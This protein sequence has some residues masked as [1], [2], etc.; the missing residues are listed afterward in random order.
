MGLHKTGRRK[1]KHSDNNDLIDCEW[2]QQT[3][4][5]LIKFDTSERIFAIEDRL[6]MGKSQLLKKLK[7]LCDEQRL[8]A[9]LISPEGL[10]SL[11]PHAF[12]SKIVNDLAP[13]P[14]LRER[15]FPR[16]DRLEAARTFGDVHSI[17]TS[18]TIRSEI[19]LEEANFEKARDVDI[20]GNQTKIGAVKHFHASSGTA[21][22][23]AEQESRAL[24]ESIKAF[25][26]DLTDLCNKHKTIFLIDAYEKFSEDSLFEDWLL[27]DFLE[28]LFL[29]QESRPDKL[30]LVIAGRKLPEF[31]DQGWI[32]Q[33]EHLVRI[34][35]QIGRWKREH[36]AE[37]MRRE[38]LE[39]NDR[40]LDMFLS[41]VET[42]VP[43]SHII[44]TIQ[45]VLAAQK[46]G[47]DDR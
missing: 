8:F 7:Q 16:F 5:D 11:S 44:L 27:D 26:N 17:F 29:N 40:F 13:T 18:R 21:Q 43:S 33:P 1:R 47:N 4:L 20:I 10:L 42:G 2:E 3:F 36:V 9:T 31:D 12:V 35:K 30:L 45:Q 41:L 32:K 19:F 39:L 24:N 37:C 34:I 25:F 46:G 14:T 38:G 22:L 15:Y 28:H 6:K 23:T